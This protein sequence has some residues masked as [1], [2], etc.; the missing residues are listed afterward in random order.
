MI[1]LVGCQSYNTDY[2]EI[3]SELKA[4][5]ERLQELLRDVGIDPNHERHPIDAAFSYAMSQPENWTTFGMVDVTIE[6]GHMWRDEMEKYL[7][8]LTEKFE[9]DRISHWRDGYNVEWRNWAIESQEAWKNFT[10]PNEELAFRVAERQHYG[11]SIMRNIKS[12]I[13]YNRYRTR[14][15]ELKW[16]YDNL[17]S[18]IGRLFYF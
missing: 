15:L 17:N 9:E 13:Y 11:G 2:S 5:N 16:L 14:A 3:I 8:R 7:E 1:S 4:E 10:V 12:K 6:H 18:D